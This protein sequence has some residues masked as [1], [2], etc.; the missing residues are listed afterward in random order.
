VPLEATCVELSVD[1]KSVGEAWTWGDVDGVRLYNYAAVGIPATEG[2][3]M[4]C[5]TTDS[6]AADV[7]YTCTPES[8]YL[9]FTVAGAFV[10]W[11]EAP[12][13]ELY[14]CERV[15]FGT[16]VDAV[17]AGACST[18]PHPGSED[19]GADGAGT[20]DVT[21]VPTA[22]P[23]EGSSASAAPDPVPSA[24]AAAKESPPPSDVPSDPAADG[25][26]STPTP[27]PGSSAG[28]MDG[29]TTANSAGG[30]ATA[31]PPTRTVRPADSDL[32]AATPVDS[33]SVAL[34]GGARFPM[35]PVLVLAVVLALGGYV[36]LAAPG[37]V[38]ARRRR[39]L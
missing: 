30:A 9:L 6:S 21:D 17:I 26:E 33:E 2:R 35:G 38:Q 20:T 32:A 13:A 10:E 15:S 1:G 31:A 36:T 28:A 7:E 39:R 3:V 4:M 34:V 18:V 8:S 12:A 37:F 27:G 24:S 11:T 16:G 19:S 22:A 23:T 25:S 14:F 5:G 29:S